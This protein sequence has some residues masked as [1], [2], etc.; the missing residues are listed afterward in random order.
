MIDRDQ[1][2]AM[3]KLTESYHKMSKASLI[4]LSMEADDKA[5][6]LDRIKEG[7]FCDIPDH[8]EGFVFRG[9]ICF[10]KTESN[11]SAES[12]LRCRDEEAGKIHDYHEAQPQS[13][14]QSS[15]KGCVHERHAEC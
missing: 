10:L 3:A 6:K 8:F 15:A 1:E 13:L 2:K 9:C 14:A 11:S 5:R 4:S 7:K 12:A